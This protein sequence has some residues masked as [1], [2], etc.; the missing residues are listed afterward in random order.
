MSVSQFYLWQG[1]FNLLLHHGS[2]MEVYT[3]V[4]TI[5]STMTS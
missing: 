5:Q 2:L 4:L 3:D 1:A